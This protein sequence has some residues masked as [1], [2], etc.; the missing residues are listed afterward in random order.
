M[1]CKIGNALKIHLRWTYKSPKLHMRVARSLQ[2][3]GPAH[4]EL[5]IIPLKNRTK[6][7]LAGDSWC[8]GQYPVWD[9]SRLFAV[10]SCVNMYIYL[11]I[12][13]ELSS[14]VP[15]PMTCVECEGVLLCFTDLSYNGCLISKC[16]RIR[17]SVFLGNMLC[18][19][20]TKKTQDTATVLLHGYA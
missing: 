6:Q 11:Y 20:S 16:F 17:R 8:C 9:A 10:F 19:Q 4:I 7:T 14:S 18:R 3:D 13:A 12:F 15:D 1:T 2:R 5:E